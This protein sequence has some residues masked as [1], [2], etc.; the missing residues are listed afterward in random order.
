MATPRHT[1][2]RGDTRP[3]LTATLGG[4]DV[5]LAGATIRFIMGRDVDGVGVV[6]VD[7]SEA[8][9]CKV[10]SAEPPKVRY[11]W[12]ADGSDTDEAGTDW[13]AEFE[14]TEATGRII[15]YPNKGAIQVIIGL[16]RDDPR[17]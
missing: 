3:F 5:V 9:R 11:E 1:M 7:Y 2:K 15:T 4:V 12:A 6:K 16:G 17:T 10:V 14:I 13:Q 8:D